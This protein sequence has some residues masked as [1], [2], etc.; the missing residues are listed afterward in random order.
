MVAADTLN[1][2]SFWFGALGYVSRRQAS[3]DFRLVLA[4]GVAL[5]GLAL[6]SQFGIS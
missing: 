4:T 3:H 1:N 6:V 2:R 5:T